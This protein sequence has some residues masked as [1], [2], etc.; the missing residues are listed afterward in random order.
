M[1]K[2]SGVPYEVTLSPWNPLDY[3]KTKE[4]LDEYVSAYTAEL[5]RENAMMRARMDRLEN[6][7]RISDELVNCLNIEVINLRMKND[8]N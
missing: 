3:I 7:L 8:P 5:E 4:Q 6:E 1:V 2:V